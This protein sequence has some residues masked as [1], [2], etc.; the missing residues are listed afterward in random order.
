MQLVAK[1]LAL[2]L[3]WGG[4]EAARAADESPDPGAP[5]AAA[6]SFAIHGQLSYVEQE[7]D[8]FRA[9]YRGPNSLSPSKGAETVDATLA[10]GGRLWRGAEGWVTPEIDQGFGLDDTLGLAGFPSGKAYKLGSKAPYFRLPRAFVRQ[11]LATGTDGEA[12]EGSA[13]QLA[14]W[15]GTDRW[16]FTLG[17]FAVTDVFDTNRYAHD[18][19]VDFFN[20]AAVDSGAFDYAADAWGYTDGAAAE[21][22]LGSWTWR[23]GV[24][25]LSDVPNSATLEHGLHEFQMILEIEKRYRLFG[26]TARIL[27]TG[28]ET[29]GRMAL[30]ADAIAL[31]EA[32]GTSPN[33]ALVRRYRS[34][35]GGVLNLEQP[36]TP[37]LGLFARVGK[38]QGN[39]EAYEFADIDRSTAVGVSLNGAAWHQPLDTLGL[40]AID[41]GIAAIREQYLND[42]GLGILVGDGRLPHPGAEQIVETYYSRAVF[43]QAFVTLDY[44]WVR[45]PA[46]NRD[47]GPVALVALRVHAAF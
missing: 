40:A 27:V 2:T 42:G 17:K 31:G 28:Y 11:S 44:Q 39:V 18:P 35:F 41:N 8:A 30:L 46:Y 29:R 47:R 25:D 22:Y 34:R 24:F 36:L 7:T 4:A 9:P 23:A 6:E 38:A 13:G 5:A 1:L 16:V 45:N 20:W 14:G 21:R 43:S 3:W 26:Q 15:R 32:S 33:P 37:T 12:V 10:L 19:G